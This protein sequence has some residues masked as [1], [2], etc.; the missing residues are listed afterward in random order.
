MALRSNCNSTAGK[1]PSSAGQA[2]EAS[3]PKS[4]KEA[5]EGFVSWNEEACYDSLL[6][7]RCKIRGSNLRVLPRLLTLNIGLCATPLGSPHLVHDKSPADVPEMSFAPRPSAEEYCQPQP[8]LRF[9]VITTPR[10][11]AETCCHGIIHAPFLA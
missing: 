6:R 1:E 9:L 4:K 10:N 11:H 7:H 5:V 2:A 3:R 8:P